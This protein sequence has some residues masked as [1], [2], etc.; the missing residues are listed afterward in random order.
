MDNTYATFK[1]LPGWNFGLHVIDMG[2]GRFKEERTKYHADAILMVSTATADMLYNV[3]PY[4]RLQLQHKVFKRKPKSPAYTYGDGSQTGSF[5]WYASNEEYD[6][7]LQFVEL[8]K[9]FYKLFATMEK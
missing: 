3:E 4:A 2:N 8:K 7:F 1:L 5:F 6:N 9:P